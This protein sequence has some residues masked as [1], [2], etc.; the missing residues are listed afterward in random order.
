MF[1]P[2]VIVVFLMT[3]VNCNDVY[4]L[5][6]GFFGCLASRGHQSIEES[7]KTLFRCD[8]ISYCANNKFTRF[9]RTVC[10]LINS[11][12]GKS[13]MQWWITQSTRTVLK[14]MIDDFAVFKNDAQCSL[15][16]VAMVTEHKQSYYCGRR[17][18]WKQYS[19]G[20]VTII[21]R[22]LMTMK[23]PSHFRLFFITKHSTSLIED[24]K[25]SQASVN[26]VISI[27][28]GFSHF[29]H[30]EGLIMFHIGSFPFKVLHITVTPMKEYGFVDLTIYDG[31][32]NLTPILLKYSRNGNYI[33]KTQSTSSFQAL[34]VV[35]M[36]MTAD[37]IMDINWSSSLQEVKH[38]PRKMYRQTKYNITHTSQNGLIHMM[39]F[40]NSSA[41]NRNHLFRFYGPD[42]YSNAVDLFCQ[43]G[44]FWLYSSSERSFTNPVL[45]LEQCSNDTFSGR[46]YSKLMYV[47]VVVVQYSSISS[48]TLEYVL[49]N[50]EFDES[51][52]YVSPVYPNQAVVVDQ[53]FAVLQ[54]FTEAMNLNNVSLYLTEASHEEFM[55]VYIN[56]KHFTPEKG[57][58]VCEAIV[59]YVPYQPDERSWCTSVV[60]KHNLTKKT[61]LSG[62][63]IAPLEIKPKLA[64]LNCKRCF[65]SALILFQIQTSDHSDGYKYKVFSNQTNYVFQNLFSYS[66]SRHNHCNRKVKYWIRKY[67]AEGFEVRFYNRER[68]NSSSLSSTV[69]FAECVNGKKF[70]I[71]DTVYAGSTVRHLSQ[72]CVNDCLISITANEGGSSDWH[73]SLLVSFQFFPLKAHTS[74]NVKRYY[75]AE[76]DRGFQR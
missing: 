41:L 43:Y 72:G 58:C 59:W 20:N 33:H 56:F 60:Q 16:H 36:N 5:Q 55:E 9:T 64:R 76:G 63:H 53:Q 48:V 38:I 2:I 29:I 11:D 47:A 24:M 23:Y 25:N 75:T 17:L 73:L 45:L 18:S 35:S 7:Y 10:G 28:P 57:G 14:W 19:E 27:N 42:T 4:V 62:R 52:F 26:R 74:Y 50:G 37:H 40:T 3:Q 32:S 8:V 61:L 65:A 44:G 67:S 12:G 70:I 15:S 21:Q 22:F 31:P 46:L 6:N 39:I 34:L 1:R 71:Q 13:Q 66:Y 49:E 69:T 54:I 68:K 30:I 51:N